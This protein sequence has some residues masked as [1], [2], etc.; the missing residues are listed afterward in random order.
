[1]MDLQARGIRSPTL[2]RVSLCK[3]ASECVH[4]LIPL[5][6]ILM[7]LT[8]QILV[9]WREWRSDRDHQSPKLLAKS[10]PGYG[11][12]RETSSMLIH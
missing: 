2:L 12:T 1:M 10:V 3:V 9:Q 5:E 11:H 7:Q 6:K 4:A 8:A